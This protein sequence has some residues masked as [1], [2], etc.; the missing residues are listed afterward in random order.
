MSLDRLA[1]SEPCDA[2]Q[3]KR[4]ESKGE[5][6]FHTRKIVAGA[7]RDRCPIAPLL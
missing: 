2:T 1:L 4:S 3:G 7:E 6:D 5:E